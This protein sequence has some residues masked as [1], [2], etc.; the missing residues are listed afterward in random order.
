MNKKSW[1]VGMM[2][3]LAVSTMVVTAPAASAHGNLPTVARGRCSD[4]SL[5]T[6]KVR[7]V[8][9][10]MEVEFQ[11]DSDFNGQRWTARIMDNRQ[12]VF[13]GNRATR[14][15][16]AAFT[17]RRVTANQVG[18]DHFVGRAHNPLTNEFCIARVNR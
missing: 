11:V 9:A 3:P 10:R 16:N 18:V 13:A 12:L 15:P 2:V 7:P 17:V 4:V 5:W 8:N 6:I 14:P 1:T